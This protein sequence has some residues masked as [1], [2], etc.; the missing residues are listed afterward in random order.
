MFRLFGANA[1]PAF[2]MLGRIEN[3]NRTCQLTP[4]RIQTFPRHE[5]A[6]MENRRK[7]RRRGPLSFE[8]LD[9]RIVPAAGAISPINHAMVGTFTPTATHGTT[10]NRFNFQ[11]FGSSVRAGGVHQNARVAIATHAT[12]VAAPHRGATVR[13]PTRAVTTT[14]TAATTTTSTTSSTGSIFSGSPTF[15]TPG[16]L[17][18]GSLTGSPTSIFGGSPTFSPPFSIFSGSP[19]FSTPTSIF[20]GSPTF[21]TPTSI[22]SGSPTSVTTPT[23]IFSGSPTFSNPASM[24]SGSPTQF[25]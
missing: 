21:S 22:F 5:D 16:S 12:Q 23:S 3:Q 2:C 14:S 19:T 20:A 1:A 7:P 17:F 25:V 24:F 6:T 18:S 9:E 13:T 15:S 10:F 11:S 8:S 4:S